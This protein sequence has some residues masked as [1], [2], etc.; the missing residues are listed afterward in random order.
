MYTSHSAF[1]L[2]FCRM[3]STRYASLKIVDVWDCCS[4]SY[5]SEIYI[6]DHGW[7][8]SSVHLLSR[9]S[10]RAPS[11]FPFSSISDPDA[12]QTAI[13]GSTFISLPHRKLVFS[14][15]EAFFLSAVRIFHL[16]AW[17]SVVFDPSS[18]FSNGTPRSIKKRATPAV[19]AV[20]AQCSK[21]LGCNEAPAIS[22]ARTCAMD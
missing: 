4:L 3:S 6:S 20:M 1:T 17:K 16:T 14:I 8:S 19:G 18:T 7:V 12:T 5:K 10:M 13:N 9:W 11:Y 2:G 22:R 21:S 15:K